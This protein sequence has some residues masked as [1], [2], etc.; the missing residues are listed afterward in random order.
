MEADEE[1][2]DLDGEVVALPASRW[3]KV[4]PQIK[5]VSDDALIYQAAASF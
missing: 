1:E 3:I 5:P 2:D 4:H